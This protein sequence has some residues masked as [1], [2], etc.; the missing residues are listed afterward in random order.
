MLIRYLLMNLNKL[1][2]TFFGF[3]LSRFAPG[4]VGTLGGLLIALI[5]YYFKIATALSFMSFSISLL[6]IGSVAADVYS[7]YTK[8]EDPSEVV[9]DEVCGY[10]ISIAICLYDFNGKFTYFLGIL[11]LNFVLFR[12]FDI[13][14]PFPISYIDNNIQN[15]FGIMFDDFI[16]GIMSGFLSLVIIIFL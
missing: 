4:T 3:G 11:L 15:G 6:L 7:K 10:L 14:K 8:K 16:A 1:F 9:I 5:F 13:L 12:F 2:V